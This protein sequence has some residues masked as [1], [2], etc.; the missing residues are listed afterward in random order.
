MGED[1]DEGDKD[2][3]EMDE[4]DDLEGEPSVEE[5]QAMESERRAACDISATPTPSVRPP[6]PHI[7]KSFHPSTPLLFPQCS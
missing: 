1:E 4:E 2:D 6:F 5:K 3:Q 7:C